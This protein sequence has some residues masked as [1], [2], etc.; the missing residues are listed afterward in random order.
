MMSSN[1]DLRS[2]PQDIF[3]SLKR[4]FNLFIDVCADDTN[5]KCNTYF[6]KEEDWLSKDWNN[7]NCFMNPPY[8][9]EI[10]KR[11]KKASEI[12]NWWVVCLLPARTDTRRFHDYI[13]RHNKVEIRFI[14]W[15]LKFW[16]SKNSAPFPSMIVVFRW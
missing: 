9:R 3:D 1:T 7:S 2:T 6:T 13:Y 10:G 12:N 16:D 4:E 14:K 8:W 11:V 15:R 5:H